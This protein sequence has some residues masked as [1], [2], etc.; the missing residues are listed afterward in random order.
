MG[1]CAMI[2]SMRIAKILGW[3]VGVLIALVALSLL[4]VKLFVDPNSYKDRIQASVK[5][6]TGRDLILKGDL[7]LSVFPWVALELGPATLSSPPGFGAEPFL[8]FQRAAVRVKLLPLL[9]KRLEVARVELDGLNLNLQKNAAGQGNWSSGKTAAAPPPGSGG[10]APELES[11]E[12]ISVT[13]GHV[14]YGVYTID[15]LS[16]ETGAFATGKTVPV[17]L[18]LDANRG[19][20]GEVFTVNGRFDFSMPADGVFHIAALNV[21]GTISQPGGEKPVP[22]EIVAP[23]L[24]ADTAKQT[25]ALPALNAS[26]SSA[27]LTL[28]V[29]GTKIVDDPHLTGSLTLSPVVLREFAPRMGV[30]LPATHDPRALA[31]LSASLKFAYDAKRATL[32]DVTMKL[33]DTTLKGHIE[34]VNGASKEAPDTLKFELGADAINLDRYRPPDSR[35]S[36]AAPTQAATPTSPAAKPA[37]PPMN[38]QGTLVLAAAHVAGLDFSNFKTTLDSSNH[39]ARLNPTQAN[40]YGGTF[41]GDITYD[42]R[43]AT[44]AIALDVHLANIDATQL[45]ANT[46]VKGRVSGK[47]N[48]NLKSTAKGAGADDITKSLNGRFDLNLTN[49]AIEGV[50]LGYAVAAGQALLNQ[51]SSSVPN[52]HKTAFDTFKMSAPIANGVATTDDLVISSAVLKVA[53]KGSIALPTSGIDMTLLVKLMKS[54]QTTAVDIPLKV[55]GTY[56]DPTIRPDLNEAAK[57]AVKDKLKDILKKN[58]LEGLFKH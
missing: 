26:L 50:D 11:I 9:S 41:L 39:V 2:H 56:T 23:T 15:N 5:S 35:A 28:A 10:S 1:P 38:I 37:G 14:V 43:V 52:T 47:A 48:V 8:A 16:L 36:A 21:N 13:H 46:S 32:D 30:A 29:N 22:W 42:Q 3:I 49:G 12:G 18:G 7:K 31:E 45:V 34:L 4:A 6:S 20:A 40:L 57:D 54:A 53:G 24:D 58:G 44:P 17:R 27:K 55:T 51:Q 25:L 33:D 19:V